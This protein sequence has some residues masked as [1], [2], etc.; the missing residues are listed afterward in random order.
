[1][2]KNIIAFSSFL[3]QTPRIKTTGGSRRESTPSVCRN[4]RGEAKTEQ[5]DDIELLPLKAPAEIDSQQ[6]VLSAVKNVN[7][8]KPPNRLSL[9]LE[10][11]SD[12]TG[13]QPFANGD[14]VSGRPLTMTASIDSPHPIKHCQLRSIGQD[15]VTVMDNSALTDF[16]LQSGQKL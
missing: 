1:M 3:P 7:L 9:V 5:S 16:I 11:D 13:Q 2:N 10:F 15:R 8:S 12:E 6:N 14:L 4:S